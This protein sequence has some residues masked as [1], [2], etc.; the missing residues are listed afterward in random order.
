M[1]NLNQLITFKSCGLIR[2]VPQEYHNVFG[3]NDEPGE[4]L[5]KAYESFENKTPLSDVDIRSDQDQLSNGVNE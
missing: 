1:V 4:K 2:L 3:L 5:Y